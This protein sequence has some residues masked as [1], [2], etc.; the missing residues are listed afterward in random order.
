[1]GTKASTAVC[2]IAHFYGH[3]VGHHAARLHHL[4]IAPTVHEPYALAATTSAIP[5]Q[6]SGLKRNVDL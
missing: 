5:L 6:L 4:L 2:S 3:C 1:M